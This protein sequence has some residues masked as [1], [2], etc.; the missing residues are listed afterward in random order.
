[1]IPLSWRQKTVLYAQIAPK[2]FA[3]A[4]RIAE[5]LYKKLLRKYNGLAHEGPP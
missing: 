4:M 2:S 5:Q 1:M 3:A